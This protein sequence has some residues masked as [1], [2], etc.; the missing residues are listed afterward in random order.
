MT[1]EIKEYEVNLI[2][3]KQLNSS[4]NGDTIEW[5]NAII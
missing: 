5:D 4:R 3:T 1:P 2:K